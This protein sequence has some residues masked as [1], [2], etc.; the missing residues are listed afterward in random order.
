[1]YQEI[2]NQI[3]QAKQQ[4]QNMIVLG[5]FNAKIGAR[6]KGN[7][8]TVTKGGRQIAKLDKQD[9]VILNEESEMCKGVST[10]EQGEEKSV[11]DY[12]ITNKENLQ[13]IKKMIIDENK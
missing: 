4:C 9:M 1:M 10:R 13:K 8:E 7:K 2:K 5:D 12:I 11:I 6:I 3:E